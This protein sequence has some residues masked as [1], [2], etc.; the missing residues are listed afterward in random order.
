MKKKH[1][2]IIFD[3]CIAYTTCSKVAPKIFTFKYIRNNR[4]HYST[5]SNTT[6]SKKSIEAMRSC[7]VSAI[8][9]QMTI[10]ADELEKKLSHINWC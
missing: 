1:P 9:Y 2:F 5:T 3:H 7:P 6:E 4:H 8:G 10:T